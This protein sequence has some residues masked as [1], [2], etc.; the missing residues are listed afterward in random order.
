MKIKSYSIVGNEVIA[1]LMCGDMVKINDLYSHIE[2]V[3]ELF[4]ENDLDLVSTHIA[5][6]ILGV[7][8]DYFLYLPSYDHDFDFLSVLT[9]AVKALA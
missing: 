8:E 7:G 4:N 5:E 6:H 1:Y 9:D 3:S 2:Y